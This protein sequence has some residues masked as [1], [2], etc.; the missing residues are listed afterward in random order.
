MIKSA[1]HMT[2]NSRNAYEC[3]TNLHT[4]IETPLLEPTIKKD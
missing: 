4:S 2:D 3:K 1:I